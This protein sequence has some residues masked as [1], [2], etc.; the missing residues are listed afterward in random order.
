LIGSPSLIL[1]D[2]PAR[3]LDASLR[4]DLYGILRKVREEYRTP[5]LIVTHDIGECFALGDEI[6]VFHGGSIVQSGPPG[7]VL[8]TPASV[9]VARMLGLYN[10]LPAEITALDPGRKTSRIR[11][12]SYDLNGPYFPGHLIGDRVSIS[13]RPEQL[14][15]F[16]RDGRPGS[17]RIPVTLEHA[18]EKLDTV[19]LQFT[20]GLSAEIPR[21]DFAA[22][23]NNKEWVIE[24][25]AERLRVI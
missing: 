2:E 21:A 6:L 18:T 1:L 14:R 5:T 10:I 4:E 17:N 24:F 8:E 3:G 9:E 15:C 25:P 13:I 19:R 7:R 20:G 23:R 22:A 12:E 11:Y 16:P